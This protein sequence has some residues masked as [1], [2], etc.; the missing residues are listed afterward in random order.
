MEDERD[1]E[2]PADVQYF[3]REQRGDVAASG[4][5]G[6]WVLADSGVFEFDEVGDQQ[7]LQR[8]KPIEHPHVELLIAVSW[9]PLLRRAEAGE[10]CLIDVDRR[11]S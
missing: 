2:R 3:A 1:R 4:S 10:R 7:P 5:A 11:P 9:P 8:E 6:K